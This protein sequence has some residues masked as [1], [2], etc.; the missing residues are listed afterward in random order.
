[1]A[2]RR[3]VVAAVMVGTC[4]LVSTACGSNASEAPRNNAPAAASSGAQSSVAPTETEEF[5]GTY[6]VEYDDGLAS[7]WTATPCGQGCVDVALL[8]ENSTSGTLEGQAHL[9]GGKWSM[10]IWTPDDTIC[11][12]GRKIAG[13]TVWTW[14]SSTLDGVLDGTH[15]DVCAN[16]LPTPAVPFTMTK[17]SSDVLAPGQRTY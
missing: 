6:R 17:K 13:I 8:T 5:K 12:D 15:D 1:V 16:G 3:P 7:T 4:L 11:S 9:K 14:D 10:S 2:K